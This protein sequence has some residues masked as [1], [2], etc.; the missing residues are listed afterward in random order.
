MKRNERRNRE[1]QARGDVDIKRVMGDVLAFVLWLSLSFCLFTLTIKVTEE[2][3]QK[4]MEEMS[5]NYK[6]MGYKL[7]LDNMENVV[8]PLSGMQSIASTLSEISP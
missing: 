5:G 4:G 8:N 2:V 6:E 7:Y 3:L 1:S